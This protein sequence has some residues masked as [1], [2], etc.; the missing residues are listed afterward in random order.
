MP[1]KM[2]IEPEDGDKEN[3]EYSNFTLRIPKLMRKKLRRVSAMEDRPAAA[4]VR[5]WVAEKLAEY[6]NGGNRLNS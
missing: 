4:Q 3:E 2:R 5:K 6:D 1:R